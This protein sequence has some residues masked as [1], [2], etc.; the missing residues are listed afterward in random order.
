MRC[1]LGCNR[2]WG[3]MLCAL[4][5]AWGSGCGGEKIPPLFAVSGKVTYNG[6]PVPGA[7]VMFFL[8]IK[9]AVK[10]KKTDDPPAL[11]RRLKGYTD[12]EGHYEL[13]WGED[14]EEGVPAGTYK[15]G[16]SAVDFEP[17]DDDEAVR[18]NKVPAR[19]GN[20]ETSGF[21]A[22]VKEDGDNVFD[23]KLDDSAPGQQLGPQQGQGRG[24]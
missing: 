5:C 22:V 11:P 8:P 7:T 9:P 6:Q 17:G 4:I 13:A 3:W 23:F 15:V 21:T 19:Y 18:P 20:P 16:I 24:D 12:D 10:G 14:H 1:L 2:K